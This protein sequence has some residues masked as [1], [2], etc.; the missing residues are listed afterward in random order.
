MTTW[1]LL[2]GLARESRHWG[3]FADALRRSVPAGDDVVALDLPGN[4]KRWRDRTPGSVERIA[5]ATRADLAQAGVRG[6]VVLVALSFGGMVALHWALR[7]PGE[8]LGCVLINSS[9]R[10]LAGPWERLRPGALVQ[11]LML[12]LPGHT[13]A[14]RERRI[15]RLTSNQPVEEATV[16]AWAGHAGTAPVSRLNMLRQLLAAA[17]FRAPEAPPPVPVLLLASRH[18]RLAS[19]RCSRA[20]ARAWGAPLREHPTAGHDL[21]LDDPH[22]VI[23]QVAAWAAQLPRR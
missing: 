14:A 8:V 3:G 4:G 20:L 18:D 11:L 9:M 7:H 23:A 21:A 16:A 15:L 22:W 17:R 6:P 19:V 5:E 12:L 13:A 2:R 1:V 10:G